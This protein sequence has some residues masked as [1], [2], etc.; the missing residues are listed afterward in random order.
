[1]ECSLGISNFLEEI[2]K[3]KNARN[4]KYSIWVSKTVEQILDY[5]TIWRVHIFQE[6]YN[7][8]WWTQTCHKLYK[9]TYSLL[10][11]VDMSLSK[12]WGILKDKEVWHTAVHGVAKS[13][14][15]LSDQTKTTIFF[16]NYLKEI[17]HDHE[18]IVTWMLE[19]Y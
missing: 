13:Q 18:R 11:S 1:M 19:L 7:S 6:F 4:G 5:R 17:N 8:L 9:H 10:D 12:L 15:R 16:W 3:I 2:S 14:T